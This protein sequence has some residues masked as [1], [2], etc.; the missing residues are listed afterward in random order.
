MRLHRRQTD[1]NTLPDSLGHRPTRP[2][3]DLLDGFLC[4]LRHHG[5]QVPGIMG[6]SPVFPLGHARLST[7]RR[8]KKRMIPPRVFA[9]TPKFSVRVQGTSR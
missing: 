8:E 3:G 5:T 2:I 1:L 7:T 6:P 4:G 9:I